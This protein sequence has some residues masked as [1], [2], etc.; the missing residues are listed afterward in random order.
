M[1][2]KTIKQTTQ[3]LRKTRGLK[4]T[5]KITNFLP[6]TRVEVG[7]MVKCSQLAA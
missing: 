5:D 6:K 2:M 4:C 1:H 3:Y 7:K